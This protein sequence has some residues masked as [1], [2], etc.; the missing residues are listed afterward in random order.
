MYNILGTEFNLYIYPLF[1]KS[2]G[3]TEHTVGA[4]GSKLETLMYFLYIF[5]SHFFPIFKKGKE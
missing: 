3:F 5:I 4:Q 1:T 2:K